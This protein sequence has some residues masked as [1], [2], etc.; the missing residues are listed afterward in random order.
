MGNELSCDGCDGAEPE[1]EYADVVPV[2][3]PEQ[4]PH[5][6]G[7]ADRLRQPHDIRAPL[8][9]RR[10]IL[11]SDNLECPNMLSQAVRA[12]II[13]V[14]VRYSEWSLYQLYQAIK[15]AAGEPNHQLDSVSLI[16]HGSP[17]QL[18]LL[19]S[20][21]NGSI[22]L[23]DVQASKELRQFL[24]F[25]AGYVA[26][27]DDPGQWRSDNK[28]RIDLMTC[29][30]D[31][32]GKAMLTCL[33][34]LT[35]VHWTPIAVE[36]IFSMDCRT[37]LGAIPAMY[38]Q[39]DQLERW[40]SAVRA[41]RE[42]KAGGFSMN[43]DSP[44][45]G[46]HATTLVT[47]MSKLQSKAVELREPLKS[48]MQVDSKV[49]QWMD[50]FDTTTETL[51][52]VHK[53]GRLCQVAG[54]VL[55]V[56]PGYA[57]IAERL[58]ALLEIPLRSLSVVIILVGTVDKALKPLHKASTQASCNISRISLSCAELEQYAID[59]QS[60][61]SEV[62]RHTEIATPIQAKAQRRFHQAVESAQRSL[63]ML[64][65]VSQCVEAVND[66]VAL[67]GDAIQPLEF[68]GEIC[69]AVDSTIKPIRVELE[70]I[71]R[72][73]SGLLN[74]MHNSSFGH[75][76]EPAIE[77]FDRAVES[78]M[79]ASGLHALLDR[80]DHAINPLTVVCDRI[81]EGVDKVL[82]PIEDLVSKPMD[83]L[84]GT[85]VTHRIIKT[86]RLIPSGSLAD[87]NNDDIIL[88]ED[89]FGSRGDYEGLRQDGL[90]DVG[91]DI[92]TVDLLGLDS[93]TNAAQSNS[94]D[95]KVGVENEDE[96]GA[97]MQPHY[98]ER[99]VGAVSATAPALV[100]PFPML[101]QPLLALTAPPQLLALPA[102]PEQH[103]LRALEA[104][105]VR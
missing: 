37:A 18:C 100:P 79:S 89:D 84:I 47:Q 26:R 8:E 46:E 3:S 35:E 54:A 1:Y 72:N 81:K 96:L 30:T 57:P 28:H 65:M 5:A 10:L 71:E 2:R 45:I 25:L 9:K 22:D 97:I 102:P 55:S 88:E 69:Q 51:V 21:A 24:I 4:P 39:G 86:V 34:D 73:Q 19:S 20:V 64:Q 103:E 11:I 92:N 49:V 80:L 23:C 94:D 70:I 77:A 98:L 50:M 42:G 12:D 95:I 41:R 31:Q 91:Q 56:I 105:V 17:G 90:H 93:N 83:K 104:V 7:R 82:L 61:T 59:A 60:L 48:A 27:P 43:R 63:E 13:S 62:E 74:T 99:D 101:Q 76:V 29:H 67:F 38:F 68:L 66:F 33:E 52:T 53:A 36:N 44:S 85:T 15:A 40:Q 6:P 32:E 78:V 75:A 14:M 58:D 87:L 16:V